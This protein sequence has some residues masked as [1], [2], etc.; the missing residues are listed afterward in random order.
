MGV[1]LG[2]G[3]EHWQQPFD[4]HP[5]T[6]SPGQLVGFGT[7]SPQAA[8]KQP[9]RIVGQGWQSKLQ[10]GVPVGAQ[11]TVAVGVCP[12]D[13]GV[14]LD[15]G[16]SDGVVVAPV[17]VTVAATIGVKVRVASQTQQGILRQGSPAS[18][19]V[20]M[21][22]TQVGVGVGPV[23]VGVALGVG[24]T[25]AV[26][27]EVADATENTVG[28]W[29]GTDRVSVAVAVRAGLFVNVG[30]IVGVRVGVAA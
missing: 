26:I 25:V 3:V 2:V 7:H 28:V 30:T 21:I 5:I 18:H 4:S 12:V 9:G 8:E 11:V 1:A 16:V 10:Y 20:K 29:V 15:V 19:S 14:A 27:I 22:C 17:G 6:W 13:V 23:G 24:V